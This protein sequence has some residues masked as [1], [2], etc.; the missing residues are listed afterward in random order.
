MQEARADFEVVAAADVARAASLFH[1]DG[2]ALLADALTAD[3]LQLARQGADRVVA[4]QTAA[5][6]LD[7]A[8]RGYARYSF[9]QQI[10]HP[11]WTQ[12][13]DLAPVVDVVTA[14]WDSDDLI[15]SGGGG[16]YSL[17]GAEIQH[18]HGD[19]GEFL[20]DPQ[21][22]TVTADLPTPFIVV[23]F[24]MVDFRRENGATRFIPCTQRNRQRPPSLEEEPEWMR[25]SI[26]RAP[27]GAA[28]IRDVRTWHGGTANLS[29]ETRVMT[30]VG[31][32]AP[33]FRHPSGR[34]RCIDRTLY[35]QLS[36]R[37]QR[38]CQ[39]LVLDS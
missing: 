17:P 7:K 1:R 25:Q 35:E 11:E 20:H 6:A 34:D 24:P 26:V 5:I 13:V 23:N 21:G 16:D 32:Y 18:L 28:L 19:I 39:A 22:R 4:E 30:S 38:W 37:G 9:G 33:W 3:Q 29:Q 36:E 27:A 8:N 2:F 15:C 31:Y 12:L 10:Q 14:I